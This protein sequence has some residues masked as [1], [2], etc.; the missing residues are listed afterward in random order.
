MGKAQEFR[1][2]KAQQLAELRTKEN[3][4]SYFFWDKVPQHMIYFFNMSAVIEKLLKD[5]EITL[6]CSR[7]FLNACKF[8]TFEHL[9]TDLR[10]V[11]ADWGEVEFKCAQTGIDTWS[12]KFSLI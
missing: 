4:I 8:D 10:S 12:Y 11:V 2:I 3:E 6:S 9:S 7:E 1:Q 5:G